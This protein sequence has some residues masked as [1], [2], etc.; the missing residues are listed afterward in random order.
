MPPKRKTS[1]RQFSYLPILLIA[2]AL[3][4]LLTVY[5]SRTVA[6][7]LTMDF[8]YPY[9]ALPAAAVAALADESLALK[10]SH[11]LA[12]E[13]EGLRRV[14]A[15]LMAGASRIEELEAENRQLRALTGMTPPRQY[16]YQACEIILRDP[17]SWD[18]YFT[19]SAGSDSGVFDGAAV[20]ALVP[21]GEELR[22]VLVGVV[23]T[24]SRHSA[25][26]V[27]LLNPELKLSARLPEADVVG[28]INAEGS[29]HA[30]PGAVELTY[31]PYQGAYALGEEVT[32][33][34][35]ETLVPGGIAIGTLAELEPENLLFG[36]RSYRR[37]ALQPLADFNKLRQVI[38]V[39]LDR[40]SR[41]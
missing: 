32:T 26:V 24:A 13:V 38:V 23:R 4:V 9:A 33:T 37:G 14:N 11:E 2:A 28:F 36:D 25:R 15:L 6:R 41:R 12:R 1:S 19:I 22:I 30:G 17:I 40:D 8:S 35:L 29:G 3:A 7:R 5:W 18:E 20:L 34:G 10:S 27:T 31:L 39:V 21:D 16:R